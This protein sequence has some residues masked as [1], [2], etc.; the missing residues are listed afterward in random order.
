M[1]SFLCPYCKGVG[2][3]SDGDTEVKDP[4]TGKV[5]GPHAGAPSVSI[6]CTSCNGTGIERAHSPW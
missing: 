5:H 3:T 6:G 2:V 1:A 4:K